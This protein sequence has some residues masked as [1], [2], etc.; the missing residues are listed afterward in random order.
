MYAT[1]DNRQDTASQFGDFLHSAERNSNH[2]HAPYHNIRA[3]GP[4]L[5]TVFKMRYESYRE[6]GYIDQHTT[7][8]FYDE[9]DSEN[10]CT[11]YLT[12]YQGRAIATIRSCMYTSDTDQ[13][14]PIFEVFKDE[15]KYNIGL[16]SPM[17]EANKFV[18]APHFQR[19]GG[20]KARFMIYANVINAALDLGAKYLVAAVREEHIAY[21]T[22]LFGFKLISKPRAYPHLKFKTALMICDDVPNMRKRL[23]TKLGERDME[24]EYPQ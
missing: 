18:M 16:D 24:K 10:N 15:I 20:V 5:N 23:D 6:K 22:A 1:N 9:F 11:S 4:Y 8:Q 21:N 7:R 14:I 12:F 2:Y 17:V 3:Y 13:S 19:R